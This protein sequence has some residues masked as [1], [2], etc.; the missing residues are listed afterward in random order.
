MYLQSIQNEKLFQQTKLEPFDAIIVKGNVRHLRPTLY[1][2][3]AHRALEYFKSDERDI[4]KPAYAFEIDQASAFDPA[5]DFIT[6]KFITKDSLSLKHKALLFIKN[7]LP[8]ILKMQ[9]LMH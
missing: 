2:L 3:L 5:T 9:N 8:F 1:D 7:L 4:D 6:R